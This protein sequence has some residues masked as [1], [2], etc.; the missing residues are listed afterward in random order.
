GAAHHVN[1]AVD[2]GGAGGAALG[3]HGLQRLPRVGGGIVFP[4]IV[5]RTPRGRAGV[6]QGEAAERVDLVVERDEGDVVRRQRHRLL[7]GPRIRCRVELVDQR[8]GRPAG[9]EA[10][11]NVELAAGG[12]AEHLFGWIGEGRERRPRLLWRRRRRRRLRRGG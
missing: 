9:G 10:A 6:G 7:L 2:R 3:R 11:K 12:G 8:L 5:E 1:L 4:C